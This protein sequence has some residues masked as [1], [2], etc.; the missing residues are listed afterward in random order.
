MGLLPIAPLSKSRLLSS[1]LRVCASSLGTALAVWQFGDACGRR[2]FPSLG[3]SGTI[4]APYKGSGPNFASFF[5]SDSSCLSSAE[6][7][8]RLYFYFISCRAPF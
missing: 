6:F 5:L 3:T 4:T 7:R 1:D 2:R 8:T